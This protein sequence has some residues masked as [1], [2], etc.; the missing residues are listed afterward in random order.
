MAKAP[1]VIIRGLAAF[2]SG[3]TLFTKHL[4]IMERFGS[5]LCPAIS[6][7]LY[8]MSTPKLTEHTSHVLCQL[9]F[10]CIGLC[11]VAVLIP[12]T[13]DLTLWGEVPF[14]YLSHYGLLTI[15]P[16]YAFTERLSTHRN[17][18]KNETWLNCASSWL[19]FCSGVTGLF[20]FNFVSILSIWSGQNLNYMTS[21]PPTP[22][23]VL[24]GQNYRILSALLIFILFI[25]TRIIGIGLELVYRT[26][27]PSKKLKKT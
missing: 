12:D 1:H 27:F 5:W 16:Y 3:L 18:D 13:S 6:T 7:G 2:S 21:P 11:I 25:V 15:T 14:F 8:V 24:D 26:I 20:Y 4:D 22:G 19:L 23:D 9:L 10:N 17:K